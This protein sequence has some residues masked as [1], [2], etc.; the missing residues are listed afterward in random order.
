MKNKKETARL[1]TALIA[2]ILILASIPALESGQTSLSFFLIFLGSMGF[3]AIFQSI[4]QER[5]GK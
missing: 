3:G 4:R 2:S 1:I 5:A